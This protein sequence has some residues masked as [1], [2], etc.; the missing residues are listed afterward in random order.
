MLQCN[1]KCA[2]L[3]AISRTGYSI[4]LMR[5]RQP[6]PISLALQGG[7]SHGAFTW[8]VLD[9]LLEDGQL[10]IEGISGASAGAINAVI[11]AQGLMNGGRDGARQALAEFWEAVAGNMP[12][13]PLESR[14]AE[15]LDSI[16]N[17][18]PSPLL[19]FMLSMSRYYSPYELNPLNLNPLRD[20]IGRQIDFERLRRECP[21][22]LFI[23]TTQVRTGKLRVFENHELSEAVLLASACLP[24]LHQAIE[25]DGEEYWDGGYSANPAMFPLL[26][27]CRTRD[28]LVVMLHPLVHPPGPKTA[29]SIWNRV[30]ELSFSATFLR[31]MQAIAYLKDRAEQSWLAMGWLERRLRRVN[32][33]LIEAEE[34][35]TRLSTSSK[36]NVHHT[37][38]SFL[39]D[40]GREQASHW[41][42][43]H[44]SCI[45][46]RSSVDL[47]ALFG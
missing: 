4:A 22:R 8:G 33:H 15:D 42:E 20:I 35:M 26:T 6:Q 14:V 13:D 18:D 5:N 25:I 41:L 47:T 23:A 30:T 44:R 12:L 40:Q 45:G 29:Q 10:S 36:A 19:K 28:I 31:E 17:G 32:F 34:L 7:G 46:T 21:V 3:F 11:L 2:M 24:A 16:G 37:F 39:R 1:I 43:R 27:R 9:R 38:L